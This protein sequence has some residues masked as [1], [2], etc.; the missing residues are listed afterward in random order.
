MQIESNR[1]ISVWNMV[2]VPVLK[3]T[4]LFMRDEDRAEVWTS[5]GVLPRLR[6]QVIRNIIW[7]RL[8]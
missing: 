1:Q 3:Y 4:N 5:V 8:K 2:F 7:S 6:A